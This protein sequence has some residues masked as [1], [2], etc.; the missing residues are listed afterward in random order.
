[1]NLRV[2]DRVRHIDEKIDKAQGIMTILE[3][4]GEYAFCVSLGYYNFGEIKD[5]YL[6]KDLKLAEN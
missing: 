2:N 6:L 4:K 3:I 5:S 1:M